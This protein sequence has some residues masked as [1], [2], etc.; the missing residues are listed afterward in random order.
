VWLADVS[1][2]GVFESR[3]VPVATVH[4]DT[5]AVELAGC[6]AIEDAR[7][8]VVRA[9]R[10]ASTRVQREGLQHAALR[11]H[12]V[13]RT[14]LHGRLAPL[15]QQ[16]RDVSALASNDEADIDV[17]AIDASGAGVPS[18][19]VT[20]VHDATTPDHG[21]A[22]LDVGTDAIAVLARLRRAVDR[23]G[24]AALPEVLRESLQRTP[25]EVASARMFEGVIETTMPDAALVE[26]VRAQLDRLLDALLAQ[27]SPDRG[28]GAT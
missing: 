8:R 18:L 11:V 26:V 13:G 23:D 6:D 2:T 28:R 15:A 7:G 10:A 19:S 5:V 24:L 3:L 14:V 12:F 1:H 4:Y 25:R 22:T 20:H 21:L 16:L 27:R 17:V 9:L